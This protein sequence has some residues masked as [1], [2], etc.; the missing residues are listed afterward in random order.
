MYHCFFTRKERPCDLGHVLE[1]SGAPASLLLRMTRMAGE[2][3][4]KS[5]Q[6]MGTKESQESASIIWF[7][8]TYK[9]CTGWQ[10]LLLTNKECISTVSFFVRNL[11]SRGRH[12]IPGTRRA[13]QRSGLPAD[14]SQNAWAWIPVSLFTIEVTW[15]NHLIPLGLGFLIKAMGLIGLCKD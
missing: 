14:W 7:Y 13:L 3:E 10:S 12:S 4:F 15:A 9:R 1:P 6:V 5:C 11:L 2:H 8:S